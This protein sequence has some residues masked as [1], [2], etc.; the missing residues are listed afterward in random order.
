MLI[1][2][3]SILLIGFLIYYNRKSI[4]E[5]FTRYPNTRLAVPDENGCDPT[6]TR[7]MY[8]NL[9]NPFDWGFT[10][11]TDRCPAIYGKNAEPVLI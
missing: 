2:I 9:L 3:V 5:S 1:I 6:F 4:F 8:H 7:G 11:S 10:Y